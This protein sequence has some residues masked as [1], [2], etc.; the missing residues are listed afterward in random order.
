MKIIYNKNENIIFYTE[1]IKFKYVF[2]RLLMSMCE[3]WPLEGRGSILK[4]NELII[5]IQMKRN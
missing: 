3:R 4:W 5:I 1:R 2:F